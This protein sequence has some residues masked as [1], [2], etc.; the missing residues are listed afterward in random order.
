MLLYG[1][2]GWAFADIK[3]TLNGGTANNWQN[4]WAVGAGAEYLLT[5]NWSMKV[6]WDYLNFGSFQWTNVTDTHFS[7]AGINCSTD[8]KVNLVRFGVNYH[9]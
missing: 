2:G 5:R 3:S 7:C 6:E 4:G 9:F 1:T 8:A